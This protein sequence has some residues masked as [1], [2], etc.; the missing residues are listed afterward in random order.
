MKE[1]KVDLKLIKI[2]EKLGLKFDNINLLKEALT[3]R[4]FLNENRNWPVNHNER[5]EYLGDAVLELVVT[6]FLFKKYKKE[7]EG[8]L[9][10]LRSALVNYQM[11][12]KVAKKLNLEKFIFVSKGEA[13]DQGKG[14]EV[15]LAN[16]IEAIIGAIYLDKGYEVVK[17]F[18]ERYIIVNLKEII[19]KKLYKDSKSY[20]QE[21]IQEKYKITPIYK[22]LK[23]I[24]PDHQKKFLIGVYLK[25]K[26]IAKGQGYSKHEAERSAALN[27]LNKIKK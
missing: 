7:E 25:D 11:L 6:E 12:A 17:K 19:L 8:K 15:I 4:S 16:C 21:I 27:A 2:E 23:E 14:K 10:A 20:L 22:V 9:T 5:L 1:V 13:K 18:I 24:G 26:L 3:H